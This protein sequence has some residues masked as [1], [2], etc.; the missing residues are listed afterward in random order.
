MFCILHTERIIIRNA[1]I[2]NIF[3]KISNWFY[4]FKCRHISKYTTVKAKSLNDNIYH[5]PYRVLPHIMMQILSD[6]V[7]RLDNEELIRIDFW[8]KNIFLPKSK[9]VLEALFD[10]TTDTKRFERMLVKSDALVKDFHTNLHYLI[11][12]IEDLI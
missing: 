9:M 8:W 6:C 7:D 4:H 12:N 3:V 1:F 2:L 10:G 11:D 5:P